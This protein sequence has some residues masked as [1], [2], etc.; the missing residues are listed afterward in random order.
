VNFYLLNKT[1]K[2]LD[3][4]AKLKI[5]LKLQLN[6]LYSFNQK[7]VIEMHSLMPANFFIFDRNNQ[8]IVCQDILNYNM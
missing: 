5:A 4:A 3:L 1:F 2:S 6:P 7:S 8:N